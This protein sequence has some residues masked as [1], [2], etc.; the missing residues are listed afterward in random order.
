MTGKI[1]YG[2]ASF[3]YD[4]LHVPRKTMEIAVHPDNRVVIK[5]PVGSS[6]EEIEERL[7]YRARW[8]LRQINYF[9]QFEPRMPKRHYIS[10][11]THLYLG[12]QYRLKV[13]KANANKV[14]LTRGRLL[15]EIAGPR[16]PERVAGLME[17][18]YRMKAREHFP[19]SLER[20]GY[21]FIR[22][23][24]ELPS[25][26]IKKM[27]T[28]WGSLSQSGTL[29]L[30][31]SLIRAPRDCIEYVITHELCHIRH[32]DHSPAFY[33]FLEKLMP[34]WEKRKRKLELLLC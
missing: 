21:G 2:T 23:G 31:L 10:G 13:L 24:Y 26:H 11:E 15:V 32:D 3:A 29:T 12:R 9:R 16:K 20:C 22:N 8:V 1:H 25:I 4:V 30:N 33:K 14:S 6:L 19:I 17:D 7:R 28:R 27:R 34:D 18:W 5:A